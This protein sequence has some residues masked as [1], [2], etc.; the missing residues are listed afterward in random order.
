M[1]LVG[2]KKNQHAW[3]SPF[4]SIHC[5]SWYIFFDKVHVQRP[6]LLYQVEK[7]ELLTEH[8]CSSW[9]DQLASDIP[10]LKDK[11]PKKELWP[12]IYFVQ[13]QD[14]TIMLPYCIHS[15]LINFT[16]WLSSYNSGS[17]TFLE[18][19]SFYQ[20]LYLTG[21]SSYLHKC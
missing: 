4:H 3:N 7:H 10:V 20:N 17:F 8:Q 16:S 15:I 14:P 5:I 21:F 13:L 6:Y 1:K 19:K 11:V 9:G 18:I 2:W 12:T